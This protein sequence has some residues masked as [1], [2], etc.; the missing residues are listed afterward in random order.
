VRSAAEFSQCR[1]YRWTLTRTWDESKPLVV[2]CGLN[3]STADET[4]DDPTIRRELGFARDWGFGR[5][6]KV[7]AYAWR[8]TD[9]KGLWQA[10][11]P[12]GEHNFPAITYWGKQ[13]A[14]FVVAWGANIQ[15]GHAWK[16]RLLLTV[17]NIQP[18]ALK[19]TKTG[20]PAHPLFALEVGGQELADRIPA[21]RDLER[22]GIIG[23]ANLYTVIHPLRPLEMRGRLPWHM[24]EQH[25]FVLGDQR[26]LPF[27]PCKGALGFWGNFEIRDGKAVQL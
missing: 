19:L 13:A 20:H 25:G 2:F 11:D 17:A 22:G 4:Q 14:L 5:Y 15:P 16:L 8:S 23:A 12:I 6:V 10:D 21:P 27:L 1:R 18:Y 7:N 24:P 3:P 26:P 9:P